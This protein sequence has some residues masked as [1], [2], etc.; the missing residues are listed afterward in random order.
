[1]TPTGVSGLSINGPSTVLRNEGTMEWLSG[2]LTLFDRARLENASTL[3]IL[4]GRL[5]SSNTTGPLVFVNEAQGTIRKTGPDPFQIV[6]GIAF[7]NRGEIDVQGGT[8]AVDAAATFTDTPLEVAAGATLHLRNNLQTFVGTVSGTP[9]GRL[10]ISAPFVAGPSAVWDFGGTGILWTG[11]D[12]LRGGRLVNRGTLRLAPAVNGVVID[13]QTSVLRNEGTMEWESGDLTLLNQARIEN[14]STLNILTG[15]LFPSSTL[16][17][18]VFVNEAQ[19]TIRKTGPDEFLIGNGILF[20]TA[21][22][23]DVQG[24]PFVVD[25]AARYLDGSQLAVADGAILHLR[26]NTQ[27]F[28]GT[29]SGTPSGRLE[30]SAPFVASPSAVWDFGGTGILW[31]GND[32]LRGGRLVNR[33]T[34]RLA[35]AVNG[36]VID[37][38][39]S[40]L[41]NEGTMEWASGDLTLLSSGQVRNASML[42]LTGPGRLFSSSTTGPFVLANEA[43]GTIRKTGTDTF[44]LH[45][46]RLSNQAGATVA[47]DEGAIAMDAA[48]EHQLGATL[49][50]TGQLVTATV[51]VDGTISPGPS[52]GLGTLTLDG[53]FQPSGG[54][55]LRTDVGAGGA[56]DVLAVTGPIALGGTLLVSVRPGYTPQLGDAFTVVTGQTPTG[57]FGSVVTIGAPQGIRFA[58]QPIVGGV[59]VTAVAGTGG[60]ISTFPD[61]LIAGDTRSVLLLGPLAG[62]TAARL[63]C[64]SCLD[65]A[66]FGS[67]PGT[68]LTPTAD[69]VSVRFDVSD[70]RVMGNY[71]VVVDLP[72][73]AQSRAALPVRPFVSAVLF[74]AEGP[75]GI[76]V[77]P[78]PEYR[79]SSLRAVN[80][81]NSFEPAFPLVRI[82]MPTQPYVRV[83][84]NSSF[85]GYGSPLYDRPTASNTSEAMVLVRLTSRVGA[86]L[87]FG[88]GIA[89]ERIRFPGDPIP[90]DTTQSIPFGAPVSFAFGGSSNL[91][92]G[93]ATRALT[94]ALHTSASGALSAYIAQV[95]AANASAAATAARSTLLAAGTLALNP[96]EVL[97]EVLARTSATVPVP[98]GLADAAEGAFQAAFRAQ[99][100]ARDL[101]SAQA[102]SAAIG[103]GGPT[104]VLAQRELDRVRASVPSSSGRSAQL[105]ASARRGSSAPAVASRLRDFFGLF[106][107]ENP[108]LDNDE[109]IGGI[110]DQMNTGQANGA[111]PVQPCTRGPF[112]P[113]DKT[114]QSALACEVGTVLVDG[115]PVQRCIRYFVP[116]AL[117]EDEIQY[118]VEFENAP[119]ATAPA[120]RVVVTDVLDEDLDPSTLRIIG[121]SSD[122]TFTYTVTGQTVTFYFTGINLPPNVNAPEGQGHV[123]FAVRPRPN[124]PD[125]TQILN[126]AE[127]VFD[128]NPPILTPMVEHVVQQVADPAV[129]VQLPPEIVSG[130]PFTAVL[131]ITNAGPDDATATSLSLAL[132]PGWTA[133]SAEAP[134]GTCD[135]TGDLV[136][137]LGS[138]P[139]D[140]SAS[141]T[142]ILRAGPVGT[143]TLLASV[144]T[145]VVD[146]RF[147]DS[148]VR[149]DV[150]VQASN[151]TDDSTQ[152]TEL[153]L[154]A[155]V[156]NP[157][158]GNARIRF[159]M[160][161]G[162]HVE[163]VAFDQ[164]G[165]E[166]AR[167]ADGLMLAGW[168]DVT[169]RP[170]R[171]A[172]GVYFVRLRAGTE[173]RVVQSLRVR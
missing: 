108:I 162:A 141:V 69:G 23:L 94:D 146:A 137:L 99:A 104:G 81:S 170:D 38:Q 27:T 166:V 158:S 56:S 29:V 91:S 17:P 160:P 20:E 74:E 153:T 84:L 63:E 157:F 33:G 116:L 73:G 164:L 135:L 1:M 41:R 122:S 112:D 26:N 136:C 95:D 12:G 102:I 93:A 46:V 55:V 53:P 77:V 47:L 128:F 92:I 87:N 124:R 32:G 18:L 132:P 140:G 7:D 155:P 98:G 144:T 11:N 72:G 8:L 71:D 67:I 64:T 168:H 150:Q 15:R 118:T 44:S 80:V 52:G 78:A 57:L 19:G 3:N 25:A 114:T 2:D 31:T 103:S 54:A 152:P 49:S 79:W 149:R 129:T 43:G 147:F 16:G 101:A 110:L 4:T 133:L 138:V 39:T 145:A 109:R 36:V 169:W 111:A 97:G 142:A 115:N 59:R 100:E 40:I 121:T 120:E 5:F 123:T 34:L 96:R 35:P 85:H 14:A 88:S 90:T 89:P 130:T 172:A 163:L 65:A 24:G 82:E 134:S 83:Q 61:S 70:P 9:S 143:A 68:A 113:N 139:P 159:G 50:G 107:C 106:T 156:P 161:A 48:F 51:E 45:G 42:N 151:A 165:R 171:L 37:G 60:P 6:S 13:G 86:P 154:A 66:A 126:S 21:G 117:R 167:I 173:T 131:S 127:I 125:A 119:I 22:L 30:I 148:A 58:A 75:F 28:V 76:P 105:T 62:A 10:E